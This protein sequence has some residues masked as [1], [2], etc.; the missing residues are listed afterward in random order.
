MSDPDRAH[1]EIIAGILSSQMV[2]LGLLIRTGVITKEQASSYF[3][4]ALKDAR[5]KSES[6]DKTLSLEMTL[7]YVRT[8]F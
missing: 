3:E 7:E 2:T 8:K 5:S 6:G 4:E 1:G